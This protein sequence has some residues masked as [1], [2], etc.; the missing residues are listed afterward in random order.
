MPFF[1]GKIQTTPNRKVLL[2]ACQDELWLNL[3]ITSLKHSTRNKVPS[4]RFPN[5]NDESDRLCY[6]GKTIK[7]ALRH[8]IS[9]YVLQ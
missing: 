3:Y 2:N 5:C 6:N 9:E 4:Q 7:A 1:F 8:E